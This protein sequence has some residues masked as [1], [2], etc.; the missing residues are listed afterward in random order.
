MPD[1]AVSVTEF[2]RGLSDFLNRVQYQGQIFNIERGKRVIARVVPPAPVQ[3]FPIAQLDAFLAGGP[4]LDKAEAE[5][6]TKDVRA[7]RSQL[8]SRR[9]PWA[10]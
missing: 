9:D 7:L 6:M 3:G 1:L 10:S 5:A 2:S 8:R 4:K